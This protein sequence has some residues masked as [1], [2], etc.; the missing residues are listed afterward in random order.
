MTN[1]TESN[2]AINFS[3]KLREFL[4]KKLNESK[5][6]IKKLKRKRAIYNTLFI[7][8]A[9]SSIVISVMLASISSLTL[10]PV[11]VPVLSITSGIL[12][13]LSAKFN[14][15][16]KTEKLKKEIKSLNRIQ[17]TLDY[18]VSCNGDLTKDKYKE[19]M[20]EFIQ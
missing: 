6:K 3:K 4:N 8:S 16:D 15:Q 19:I 10:P 9:G 13:G 2:D 17:S 7:T 5:T 18:I 12:T 20:S 1:E 11:V 14:I